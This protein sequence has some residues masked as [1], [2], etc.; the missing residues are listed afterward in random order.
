MNHRRPAWCQP[1]KTKSACLFGASLHSIAPLRPRT[2]AAA[3]A[4]G[5]SCV[6]PWRTR[7]AFRRTL[8]RLLAVPG[9]RRGC[10]AVLGG[11]LAVEMVVPDEQSSSASLAH[12]KKNNPNSVAEIWPFF[13]LSLHFYVW[14]VA[15]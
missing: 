1:A 11:G 5:E 8:A 6:R 12:Q 15:Y 13:F 3:A 4:R 10:F 7:R 9:S 14:L 2:C